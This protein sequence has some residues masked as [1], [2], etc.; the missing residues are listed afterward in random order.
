[1]LSPPPRKPTFLVF[2]PFQSPAQQFIRRCN[3]FIL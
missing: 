3:P 1:M 2:T